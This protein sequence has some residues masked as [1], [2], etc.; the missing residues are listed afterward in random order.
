MQEYNEEGKIT[1][2]QVFNLADVDKVLSEIGKL[3][4]GHLVIGKLPN[5]ND[6]IEINGLVYLVKFVDYKR[7]IV[8]LHIKKSKD[9]KEISNG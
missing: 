2:A 6:L 3:E 1:K 4:K 7:G 8:Q 5:K 9:N